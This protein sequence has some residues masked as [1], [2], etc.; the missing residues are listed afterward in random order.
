[1]RVT[2]FEGLGSTFALFFAWYITDDL[3]AALALAVLLVGWKLVAV[4]DR[5]YVLPLAYTFHWDQTSLGLFYGGITGRH[6]TAVDGSDYQ[7]MVLIGLGCCLAIA[8]GIRIGA[9][10]IKPPDPN[11]DRPE[12]AC[13]F[14]LLLIIYVVT[15]VLESGLTTAAADYPTIRQ[16]IVTFDCAR[17]GILFLLLRRLCHPQPRWLLILGVVTWEVVL[18]MTGFFAG[19]RE[20]MVLAALAT[21]EV[22]DRKN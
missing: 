4:G 2:L 10:L 7:P 21:M 16:I 9:S 19:F 15:V 20:P 5:L 17:L 1:M 22:F 13:S 3:L 6:L 12:F 8:I 11:E 14:R 18:G